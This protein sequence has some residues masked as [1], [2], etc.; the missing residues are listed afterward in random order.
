ML[1]F[2]GG[3]VCLLGLLW[4]CVLLLLIVAGW[5][6]SL[7]WIV[8]VLGVVVCLGLISL[9]LSLLMVVVLLCV[10]AAIVVWFACLWSW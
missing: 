10:L 8:L 6:S 9:V 7:R 5:R 4:Y 1:V 3:L 2:G